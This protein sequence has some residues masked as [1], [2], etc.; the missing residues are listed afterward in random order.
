[1]DGKDRAAI[2]YNARRCEEEN[3]DCEHV[4]AREMG[5]RVHRNMFWS[6]LA[7]EARSAEFGKTCLYLWHRQMKGVAPVIV[8]PA[9]SRN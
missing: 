1:M 6:S 4:G 9:F 3:E 5:S 2:F 8:M 7:I